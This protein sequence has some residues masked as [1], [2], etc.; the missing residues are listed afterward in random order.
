MRIAGSNERR[1]E[2]GPAALRP[3]PGRDRDPLHSVLLERFFL[4]ADPDPHK[5]D[6]DPGRGRQLH[7]YDG[8]EWGKVAA[9]G[10]MVVL[11]VLFFSI[12][13]RKFLVQGLTAALKG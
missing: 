5:R 1:M 7:D 3:G 6:D 10:T 11:S 8:W 4:C 12:L 13:V 2:G 9:G